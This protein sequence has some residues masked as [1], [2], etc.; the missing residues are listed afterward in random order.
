[1]INQLNLLLS[2]TIKAFE[3]SVFNPLIIL[4]EGVKQTTFKM[5]NLFHLTL[6]PKTLEHKEE[7][8]QYILSLKNFQYLLFAEHIG[9]KEKHEHLLVQLK[10]SQ[11]KLSVKKLYGAH[12]VPR[13]PTKGG[14]VSQLRDYILCKTNHPNHVGVTAILKEE[15]GEMKKKGGNMTIKYLRECND[16]DEIPANLYNIKRKMNQETI[17][18]FDLDNEDDDKDVEVFFIQG[19]SG[20]CKSRYKA[21][22]ILNQY[23]HI[24]GSKYDKVKF[25]DPFWINVHDNIHMCLYD[26]WRDTHMDPSTF[27]SFIEYAV[28]PLR[29]LYG[30]CDNNYNII[31]ITTVLKIDNIWNGFVERH[32][33]DTK[34]QWFRRINLIDC[35]PANN[36]CIGQFLNKGKYKSYTNCFE[37][38]IDYIKENNYH[39]TPEINELIKKYYKKN[40]YN[41]N[42]EIKKDNLVIVNNI[43]N[44]INNIKNINLNNP[45]QDNNNDEH[46][47]KKRKTIKE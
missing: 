14:T 30:S 44:F 10:R 19:P 16:E 25:T 28:N 3:S 4:T 15:I 26:E 18:T 47:I 13:D 11:D 34:T 27:L 32:G 45:R 36:E 31:V 20:I 1:M 22:Q 46:I 23:K 43:D 41:G 17:G 39:I 6:N 42:E 9:Q 24:Y 2:N 8:K 38:C 40:G 29:I 7:I 33:E 35:Y 5:P 21:K 37:E 12:I